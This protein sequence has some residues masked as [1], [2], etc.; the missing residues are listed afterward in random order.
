MHLETPKKIPH[1]D[2]SSDFPNPLL[3]Q[4]SKKKIIQPHLGDVGLSLRQDFLYGAAHGPMR[5][6]F[7]HSSASCSVGTITRATARC[8]H[9]TRAVKHPTRTAQLRPAG[10]AGSKGHSRLFRPAVLMALGVALARLG[11]RCAMQ[12]PC[13]ACR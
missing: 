6:H 2:F 4:F 12:P 5:P 10:A 7:R 9:N 8:H 13:N 11:G 1:W 3:A